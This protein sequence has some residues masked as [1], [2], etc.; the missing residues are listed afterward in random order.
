MFFAS[1]TIELMVSRPPKVPTAWCLAALLLGASCGARSAA[2]PP[3]AGRGGELRVVLP[4]EPRTL[5]PNA[6][7]DEGAMLLA[8]NLYSQLI[9]LDA[10]S[11]LF[12]DLAESW[13]VEDGGLRYVFHLRDGVRWHD[14]EPLTAADVRWTFERL[15]G[16]PGLAAEAIRRIAGID[17]PDDRTI[18]VRLREPWSPFLPTVAGYGVYI[19]PRHARDDQVVGSGPFRLGSWV[20][21]RRITLLPNRAFYRPG[22]YLDRVVYTFTGD[23]ERTAGM[24]L[25]GAVDYTLLRPPLR[26]IPSLERRPD[27]RVVTSPSDARFYCGFNLR[28][29]PFDDGRVREAVNRAIDRQEILRHALHG[30]GAPAF[31]FYTPAVAWAYNGEAQV[32]PFDRRRARA[33]LAAAGLRP[34]SRGTVLHLDL[35]TPRLDPYPEIALLL[36]DQLRTVGIEARPVVLPP[37][38]CMQRTL[39]RHDFDLSLISGNEGPDP[40]GLELRFGTHG[41]MQFMGYASPDLDAAM[42]EGARTVD[43]A[44]RARSYFRAQTILAR[45]LPIAPLAEGVHVVVFRRR[46][47]GLPRVEARGLVPDNEYSLVRVLPAAEPAP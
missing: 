42:A 15:A 43:L 35:L 34:D 29:R 39:V 47:S 21:G 3:A 33:L 14:G 23:G 4:F 25:S 41:A 20:R 44:Q 13:T 11:R 8:P 6:L 40:E 16:R 26:L 32:P 7:H 24:L 17:V 30:Y 12:P 2:T 10:D 5:D 38:Q 22:P 36:R 31:G 45:D 46:V 28:R 19:L 37:D 9:A 18:E 27:L 1:K